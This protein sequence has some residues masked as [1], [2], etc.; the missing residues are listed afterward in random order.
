MTKTTSTRILS[1][2]MVVMA[3]LVIAASSRAGILNGHI[4][5]FGGWTGSVP[6]VS[7]STN[8]SGTIDYAVFT[9]ND[10]NS[11]FGGLGYVPAGPLVYTYQ[12]NNTG[13]SLVSTEIVGIVNTAFTIGTFGPLNAGDVDATAEF[14]DGGG[15]ANWIFA[16]ASIPSGISS[17]GLAFSSPQVP[18][19]GASLT[20][21]GG[22]S[23]FSVG[24]PTPG[25][26]FFIPEPTSIV[27]FGSSLV[28]FV[29][30]RRRK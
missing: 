12:V 10:F 19:I 22:E 28:W 3:V 16:P 20:I 1:A 2:V 26:T 18:M 14:F 4:D 8:L 13:L 17:F 21:N 27:M 15:N 9:A 5:A 6:Y 24:L 23:A 11:N 29:T 25:P 7:A 30:R